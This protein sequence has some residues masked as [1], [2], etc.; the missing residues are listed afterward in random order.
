VE[1]D[2]FQGIPPEIRVFR[3]WRYD[4]LYR[5]PWKRK[6]HL[7]SWVR[8]EIWEEQQGYRLHKGFNRGFMI[9]N[10][11]TG[12][13]E[14]LEPENLFEGKFLPRETYHTVEDQYDI[15][16][17][18]TK[19]VL[20]LANETYNWLITNWQPFATERWPHDENLYWF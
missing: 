4:Q 17:F 7:I 11:T 16:E 19:S 15:E 20:E 14:R 5:L 18:L 6:I 12:Q 8:I 3:F 2:P 9:P 1:G 10:P 13:L